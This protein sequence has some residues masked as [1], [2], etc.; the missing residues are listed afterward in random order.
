[1]D[2]S[3]GEAIDLSLLHAS[4]GIRGFAD[5]GMCAICRIN[6]AADVTF[7]QVGKKAA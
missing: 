1:M 3:F 4:L 7:P 5:V 2:S 6:K